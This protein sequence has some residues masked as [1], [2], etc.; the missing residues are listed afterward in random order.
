[1]NR[2]HPIKALTLL[3]AGSLAAAPASELRNVALSSI[4]AEIIASDS[5][6][7]DIA[8]LAKSL[9]MD[10]IPAPKKG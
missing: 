9:A 3:L 4:G 10:Q 2:K 7:T 6:E 8:R 5:L 1:M